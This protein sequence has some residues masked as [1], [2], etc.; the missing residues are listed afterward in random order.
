MFMSIANEG[1][2]LLLRFFFFSSS[3]FLVLKFFFCME[4]RYL[5]FVVLLLGQE[6]RFDDELNDDY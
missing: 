6:R 3:F 1:S 4:D 5:E 2:H